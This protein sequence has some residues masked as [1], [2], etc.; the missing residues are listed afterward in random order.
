MGSHETEDKGRGSKG[1]GFRPAE[2]HD[3]L[4]ICGG[5]AWPITV[6]GGSC[7]KGS[8]TLPL[9]SFCQS[10]SEPD[11]TMNPDTPTHPVMGGPCH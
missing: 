4:W 3:G 11:H 8:M 7:Q 2:D 1:N 6:S 9:V 5:W 10:V